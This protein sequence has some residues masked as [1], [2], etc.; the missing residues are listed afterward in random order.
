[1]DLVL[2][3]LDIRRALPHEGRILNSTDFQIA[4]RSDGLVELKGRGY[5]HGAGMCQWG[6]I[7]RA[8]AGQT[9]EEILATYYPGAVL[10][11]AY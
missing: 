9:Y 10:V 6:A 8:R 11:N 5:G 7:G 3:R 4:Q 1:M 2:S